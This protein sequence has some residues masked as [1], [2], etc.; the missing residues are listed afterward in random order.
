MSAILMTTGFIGALV[1][2]SMTEVARVTCVSAS[3]QGP[4]LVANC[5]CSMLPAST[6]A[7]GENELDL[8]QAHRACRNLRQVERHQAV[9]PA[10]KALASDPALI[11]RH[12]ACWLQSARRG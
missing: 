3:G 5:R 6:I 1:S 2:R 8:R 9:I 10:G 7:N 4:S 12:L 11:P